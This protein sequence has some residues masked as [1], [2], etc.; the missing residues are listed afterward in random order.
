MRRRP[1]YRRT[2]RKSVK[3]NYIIVALLCLIILNI[4][5]MSIN[6]FKN[7]DNKAVA[8]NP[9]ET[10]SVASILNKV[11]NNLKDSIPTFKPAEE[12]IEESLPL[13]E[14]LSEFEESKDY[15]IIERLEEYESLIIIKDSDGISTVENIPSPLNIEKIQAN[16]DEPYIALY[17]THASEAYQPLKEDVYHIEDKTKNIIG[18]GEIIA[19]VLEANNHKT[20]HIETY[21]DRPSYNQSYSRSLNTINTIK[22][23]EKNIKVFLDIHRD[24]FEKDSP[25]FEK[26]MEKTRTKVNGVDTAT[27]SLVVGPQTPNY[28]SVLN[29]AKYIKAVSDTL[30]PGLCTGII[31][32]PYG[33]FNLYSSNHAA[34]IE[35][36]SNFNTVDEAKES[37]KLIGEI[38]SIVFNSLQE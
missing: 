19:T 37:G 10:I 35:V 4:G 15:F 20:K 16:R 2:K 12:K 36:G 29:F 3:S 8:A 14:E 5:A 25:Y 28:E 6:I 1:R 31:I 38:L 26:F 9:Q 22:E 21:H 30:Y 7:R 11:W 24:G 23:D 18:V 34:L 17:H 32:K 33:K 27:F 13:D